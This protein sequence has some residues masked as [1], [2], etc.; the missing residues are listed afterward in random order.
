MK[1]II[2][3]S[4]LLL[5][6]AALSSCKVEADKR[7]TGDEM[8]EKLIQEALYGKAEQISK[9]AALP[10]KS[11]DKLTREYVKS[12]LGEICYD[13]K[14]SIKYQYRG[15]IDNIYYGE[16][17]T[18]DQKRQ[19]DE[20]RKLVSRM[21]DSKIATYK[22]EIMKMG[23]VYN[24]YFYITPTQEMQQYLSSSQRES[25]TYVLGKVCLAEVTGIFEQSANVS[26]AD[27]RFDFYP[28]ILY[29]HLDY[30][31]DPFWNIQRYQRIP[32]A[33]YDDGWRRLQ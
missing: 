18:E 5:S 4:Q 10:D 17:M 24:V 9:D 26:I 30:S 12:V 28:N 32:F 22:E 27:V 7:P 19:I 6:L 25:G 29:A 11:S 8:R 15:S 3:T 1:N 13:V 2:Y 33:K 21:Q 16:E 31:M 20:K 23:T 14:N